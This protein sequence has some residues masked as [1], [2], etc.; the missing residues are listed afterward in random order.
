LAEDLHFGVAVH[1]VIGLG[2]DFPGDGGADH[3]LKVVLVKTG[4]F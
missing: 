1:R 2:V 4:H 3:L